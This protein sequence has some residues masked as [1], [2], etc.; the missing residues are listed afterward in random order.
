[1]RGFFDQVGI[2]DAAGVWSD[3]PMQ[4][5]EFRANNLRQLERQQQRRKA[6]E[7]GP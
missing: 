1:M 2:G 6:E 5:P 3:L 4:R 7:M